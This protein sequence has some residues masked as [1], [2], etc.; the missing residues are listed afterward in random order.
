M[1]C[2]CFAPGLAIA[3][4]NDLGHGSGCGSQHTHN[5]YCYCGGK[6]STSE[7]VWGYAKCPSCNTGIVQLSSWSQGYGGR[8]NNCNVYFNSEGGKWVTGDTDSVIG[9]TVS[10]C[11]SEGY[12]YCSGNTHLT[13]TTKSYATC[14]KPRI[15]YSVPDTWTNQDV[16]INYTG[17]QSGSLTFTANGTQSITV[18]SSTGH[19]IREDITI[20]KIDKDVPAA[21]SYTLN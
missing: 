19:R 18:T 3:A 17:S 5:T 16:T 21:P 4:T 1:F 9:K 6:I 7:G 11:C 12:S 15:N 14:V 2:I 10:E 8:C 20:Y 13:C